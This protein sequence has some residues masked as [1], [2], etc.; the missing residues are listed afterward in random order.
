[1]PVPGGA[2]PTQPGQFYVPAVFAEADG[3][4]ALVGVVAATALGVPTATG[5]GKTS[6]LTGVVA[7]SAEG[8]EAEH[9]GATVAAAGVVASAVVG[10]AT[11]AAGGAIVPPPV[12]PVGS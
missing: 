5:T 2:G 10:M 6:T 3:A 4:V 9:A 7:L 1:M 12:V 8:A 11:A